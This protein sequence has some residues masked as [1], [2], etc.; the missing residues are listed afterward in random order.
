MLDL[1]PF[2]AALAMIGAAELGDKT[3]LLTFGFATRY[4]L[5]EVISAVSCATAA[6]MAAAVLLGGLVSRYVPAF[7]IQLLAG[8]LFV[9]FGLQIL[10]GKEEG[11]KEKKRK[12]HRPFWIIFSSFLLAELGDKT[13]LATLALSARFG[14]PFQVFLGATLGMVGINVLAAV[15]GKY[16]TRILHE[17]W[18]KF[19]G[20]AV[21]ILFGA[22]TLGDAF[23]W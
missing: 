18:I 15:L 17:R 21:F 5:W 2:L 7:Y 11:E 13:Q 22:W 12:D 1:N 19:L 8:S 3:Q 23:L 10:L 6:L 4:P 14:S 16:T 20:A 9:F